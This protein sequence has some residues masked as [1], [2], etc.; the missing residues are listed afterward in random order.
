MAD[1][2]RSV[3]RWNEC[4]PT[5]KGRCIETS[6]RG[7]IISSPEPYGVQFR[8]WPGAGIGSFHYFFH[9]DVDQC[10]D[11]KIVRSYLREY[12]P[13]LRLVSHL[14]ADQLDR[15]HLIT[16]DHLQ[17]I[18]PRPVACGIDVDNPHGSGRPLSHQLFAIGAV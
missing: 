17:E 18:N 12:F 6:Q 3:R 14:F 1:H 13:V 15:F 10:L 5:E 2:Q 4:I 8:F 16:L 7:R 9:P 11:E